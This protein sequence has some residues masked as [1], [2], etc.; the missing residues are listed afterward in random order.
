[1]LRTTIVIALLTAFSASRPAGADWRQFRG[2]D[3]NPVAADARVGVKWEAS[4]TLWKIDLPGRGPSSPIV[5]DDRVIVTASSGALDQRLHVLCFDVKTGAEL[6][7]RRFRATGRTFADG[8][9]ANAAPTPASDGRRVFAFFSSNDLVCL[10]LD[11]GFQ[12]FR[13]LAYDFPKA[14]NDIGMSSSPVVVDETV[15]VQVEALGAAFAT[16]LDCATGRTRWH[17]DRELS[18]VWSS[19]VAMPVGGGKYAVLLQNRLGMVAVDARV[20]RQLW[21]LD[22]PCSSISSS[23]VVGEHL[24]LPAS[25]FTALTVSASQE[26]QIAWESMKLRPSNVSP[27]VHG[28]RVYTISGAGVLSCGNMADGAVLWQVRLGKGPFWATPVLAGEH[29][30]CI[31]REGTVHVVRVGDTGEIVAKNELGEIIQATPAVGDGALLV[32]S[33]GHL[34]KIGESEE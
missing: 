29:L 11:G 13:G 30:Y 10:D 9:S 19:P 8:T 31:N 2:T 25:P 14:G 28:G 7:H 5:V 23:L 26:P 15:V 6:W 12:W 1:M 21:K 27:V 16:G 22:L 4:D 17:L 24:L 3:N 20:G 18:K 32:R 33:D 34:W